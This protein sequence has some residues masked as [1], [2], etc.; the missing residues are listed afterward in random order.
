M[1]D[2]AMSAAGL[3]PHDPDRFGLTM[4]AADFRARIGEAMDASQREPVTLTHRGRPRA[5][6]VSAEL[7]ERAM[8][9]LE[10]V[11]DL[12]AAAAARDDTE[13]TVTQAELLADLGL[14]G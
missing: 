7:Y 8:A 2:W 10:D 11:E 12:A 6:L 13:P 5:V 3:I 4:T 1:Y 14:T 9:A